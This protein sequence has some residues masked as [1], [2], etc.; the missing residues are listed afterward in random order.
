MKKELIDVTEFLSTR[1]SVFIWSI[2]I[3]G[4]LALNTLHLTN[5][6]CEVGFCLVREEVYYF[7][8]K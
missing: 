2:A 8:F 5:R 6:S 4:S 1:G 7:N 3:I